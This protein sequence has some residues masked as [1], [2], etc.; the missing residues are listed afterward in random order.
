MAR[1]TLSSKDPRKSGRKIGD[2]ELKAASGGNR[3]LVLALAGFTAIAILVIAALAVFSTTGGGD[4]ENFTANNQG[5]ISTGEQVP[6]FTGENVNGGGNVSLNGDQD[7]TMLVFFAS[8]CPHCQREAPVISELESQYDGLKVI[9]AGIDGT[10][11]DDAEAVR[12]F[13]EEYDIESPAMYQPELGSPYN[14]QGYP[15]VYVL[16]EDDE[17]VGAHSGEAPREVFEGW[18]EEALG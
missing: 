13:V 4:A 10:Q 6:N 17:V 7:A 15:T 8:W 9:M 12:R 18:I 5:L 3:T 1:N 16:N 14:V 11:G 2:K